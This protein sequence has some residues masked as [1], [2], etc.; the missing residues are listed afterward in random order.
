MHPGWADTPG[1]ADALPTFHRLMRP[2]LRSADEGV[3][4]LVWLASA[5]E[6][7]T[8]GGE[9]FLDRRPRPFDRVRATRLSARD[10]RRLWRAVAEL[11]GEPDPLPDP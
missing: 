3:D 11:S 10:R 9:L 7:G 8:H 1:L 2:L 5:P 4:T 6:A